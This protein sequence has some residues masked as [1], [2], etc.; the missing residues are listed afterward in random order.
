LCAAGS[1]GKKLLDRYSLASPK[2]D[3]MKRFCVRTSAWRTIAFGVVLLSTT[4][5][6]AVAD[7]VTLQTNFESDAPGY[8]NTGQLIGSPN[9]LLIQ[10]GAGSVVSQPWSFGRDIS[11]MKN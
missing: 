5:L 7:T 10:N 1:H 4:S 6:S 3:E 11:R 2:G 8:H 9:S